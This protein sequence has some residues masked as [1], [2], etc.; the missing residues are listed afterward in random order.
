MM[1]I[2][3]LYV[4]ASGQRGRG[5]FTAT[6]LRPGDL[7]EICPVIII[8]GKDK[9]LIDQ[10]ILHDYYFIWDENERSIDLALGY[11]MLYNHRSEANAEA[12]RDLSAEVIRIY[13]LK[14]VAAGE[15]IFINYNFRPET[16]S[17]LWFKAE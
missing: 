7:I 17:K 13:C 10:S 5:V 15:E 16:Q 8:P 2:P 12:E 9:A 3:G 1:H 4:A 11:G 14:S 6:E